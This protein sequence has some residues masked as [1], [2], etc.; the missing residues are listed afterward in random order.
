MLRALKS[1]YPR[2]FRNLKVE[3]LRYHWGEI[4]KE[5]F[6]A[7][8]RRKTF[9]ILIQLIK[10]GKRRSGEGEEPD[11][12]DVEVPEDDPLHPGSVEEEVSD[13]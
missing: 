3:T 1:E 12:Q 13:P 5:D 7:T 2:M 6:S 10:E 8:K 9:A 11:W 4:T